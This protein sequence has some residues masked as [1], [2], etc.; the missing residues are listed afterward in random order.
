MAT[1]FIPL[2][3]EIAG[4]AFWEII[5]VEEYHRASMLASQPESCVLIPIKVGIFTNISGLQ[6]DQPYNRYLEYV[7]GGKG[8]CLD[9]DITTPQL[10]EG[11]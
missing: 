6:V 4:Y 8:D 11:V 2:M 7:M 5:K 3:K 10:S 1:V 9:I